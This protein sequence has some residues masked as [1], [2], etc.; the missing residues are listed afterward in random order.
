MSTMSALPALSMLPV[1][2]VSAMLAVITA[3]IVDAH[4]THARTLRVIG[5]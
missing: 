1:F 5:T 3:W 2:V 4:V